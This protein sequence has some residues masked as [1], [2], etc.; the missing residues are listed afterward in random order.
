MGDGAGRYRYSAFRLNKFIARAVGATMVLP[1]PEFITCHGLA[2]Y[3]YFF[4]WPSS[5]LQQP[6]HRCAKYPLVPHFWFI[7]TERF[8]VTLRAVSHL[9][10]MTTEIS[11]AYTYPS[12]DPQGST[13]IGYPFI[14]TQNFN[15]FN[16]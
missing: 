12:P 8:T 7:R 13:Y 16:I 9:R 1:E 10:L 6:P 4:A 3:P 2:A 5:L 14:H 15:V 11:V